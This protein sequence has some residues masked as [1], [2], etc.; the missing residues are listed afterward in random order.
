[1]KVMSSIFPLPKHSF[2][3]PSWFIS[4]SRIWINL[5]GDITHEVTRLWAYIWTAMR[6]IIKELPNL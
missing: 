4:F 1:V 3:H 2:C 5:K 6:F